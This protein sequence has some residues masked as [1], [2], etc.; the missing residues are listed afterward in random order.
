MCIEI[1]S[2]NFKAGDVITG[3]AGTEW[4]TVLDVYPGHVLVDRG[5][6]RALVSRNQFTR[7]HVGEIIF[8]GDTE[9]GN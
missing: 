7:N 8:K 3:K 9:N 5:H 1:I 2:V 6:T 4:G